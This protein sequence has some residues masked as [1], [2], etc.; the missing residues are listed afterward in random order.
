MDRGHY[1]S[2]P[3][4]DIAVDC[5]EDDFL[6]QPIDEEVRALLKIDIVNLRKGDKRLQ[7][8]ILLDSIVLY[9]KT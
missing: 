7:R 1:T 2:T 3:D 9:E 4:I 6:I 5:G 8:E